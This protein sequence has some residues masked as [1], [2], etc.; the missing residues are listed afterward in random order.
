[1]KKYFLIEAFHPGKRGSM[2]NEQIP[3]SEEGK[4]ACCIK[5]KIIFSK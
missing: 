5:K 4:E 2:P 3:L 1:M